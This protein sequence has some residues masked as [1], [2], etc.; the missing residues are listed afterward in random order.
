MRNQEGGGG[1]IF[2]PDTAALVCLSRPIGKFTI[3][4]FH[5][6][7]ILNILY[8]IL[9]AILCSLFLVIFYPFDLIFIFLLFFYKIL[10][11]I[12]IL[13]PKSL[14]TGVKCYTG[15]EFRFFV[16]FNPFEPFL[17]F[18]YYCS[19]NYTWMQK[20]WYQEHQN[21]LKTEVTI[22]ASIIDHPTPP[23]SRSWCDLIMRPRGL[24]VRF[25]GRVG[26]GP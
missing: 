1:E 10:I 3:L 18:Y 20:F 17:I 4:Y 21:P 26:L 6:F 23:F 5:F 2:F 9:A 12:N 22:Q 15:P 25:S 14:E 19:W 13:I 7:S 16:I 11:N 24:G 8:P